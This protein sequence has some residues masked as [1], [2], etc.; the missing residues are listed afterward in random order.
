[1]T[2]PEPGEASELDGLFPRYD[3]SERHRIRIAAGPAAVDRALRT[4]TLGET[5]IA[6]ALMTVRA[7][8][9]LLSGRRLTWPR[10]DEPFFARTL[11]PSRVLLADRPGYRVVGLA[12]PMWA[13]RGRL[14]RFEDAP[15]FEAFD[16]P[17]N[18][19]AVLAF[20]ITAAG[21]DGTQLATETR[22]LAMDPDSR[23]RFARYW[24]VIRPW[25]GLIRREW[26]RAIRRRAESDTG[27]LPSV[28]AARQ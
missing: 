24:F 8:P 11:G 18:V 5:P 26:L 23:R 4:F 21:D 19:K 2:R 16:A 17:G 9:A 7:L 3:F 22:V 12:G 13:L 20:A 6:R 15:A 14:V 27:V 28:V 10:S 1:M 25:S